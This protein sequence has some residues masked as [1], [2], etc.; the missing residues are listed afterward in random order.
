MIFHN[1]SSCRCYIC[2]PYRYPWYLN[3]F[4]EKNSNSGSAWTTIGGM[5]Q[6][7]LWTNFVRIFY[8]DWTYMLSF[9][10]IKLFK[11]MAQVMLI[12]SNLSLKSCLSDAYFF[13]VKPQW[14]LRKGLF[15]HNFTY[16]CDLIFDTV[17]YTCERWLMSFWEH[18]SQLYS[19]PKK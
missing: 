17:L 18:L 15:T 16:L 9:I 19:K 12:F 11:S 8:K 13:A 10:S 6:F 14:C 7:F 2:Y 4:F 5:D 3:I 1:I